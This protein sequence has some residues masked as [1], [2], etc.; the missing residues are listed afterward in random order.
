MR[1]KHLYPK[2]WKELSW[3]CRELAHWL[4]QTCGV[5]QGTERESRRGN[6]YRVRLAAC[7]VDHQERYKPDAELI[8]LCEICHWHHDFT[9]W[10]LD[11]WRTLEALKHARLIT[12]KRIAQ[13][14]KQVDQRRE[15]MYVE[16]MQEHGHAVSV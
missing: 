12:P 4:C 11:Q 9:Q 8:C 15:E 10:Q 2:N 13:A 3:E 5:P 6:I 14:R 7:H 1:N 16:V